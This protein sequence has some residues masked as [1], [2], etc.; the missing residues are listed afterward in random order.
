MKKLLSSLL[1]LSLLAGCAGGKDTAED[2]TITVGA[3]TAPHAEILNALKDEVA[4]EGYEL[5]VKEFDD[6]VVPNTALEEGSLDANYFQHLPYLEQFNVDNG[7]HIVSVLKVHFEPLGIYAGKAEIN[8][9]LTVDDIIEGAKIGVPNDGTNE[10][11]ALQLL[12]SI[13][14][15]T[16]KEG[17]GLEAT[18]Q[19]IVENPKNVEIVELEAKTIPSTL[20]TDLDYGVINGNYALSGNVTDRI[21][22]A[23]AKDSEGALTFG[24]VLAVREGE[25]ETEKTKVLEKVLTS[26][27]CRQFI[28][29]TYDGLVVPVF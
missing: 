29:D 14:V 10:A 17:V 15:I 1:A 11:R 9:S 27:K 25:E 13:G 19:D 23:E 16:L 24:N 21:C 2:K 6:Y 28:E 18:K 20:T 12:A 5:V 7:T 4:A 3:S 22:I 8:N 26:E